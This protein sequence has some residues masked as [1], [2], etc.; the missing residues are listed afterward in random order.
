LGNPKR[1]AS[2]LISRSDEIAIGGLTTA[3]E[4]DIQVPEE[5]SITG[6]DGHPFGE[7]FGLTTMN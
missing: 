5:L 6:I 4:L 2:V 1:Q 3:R 7:T